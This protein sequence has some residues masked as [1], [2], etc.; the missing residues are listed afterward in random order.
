MMKGK[1]ENGGVFGGTAPQREPSP[2]IN[3][4]SKNQKLFSST[5]NGFPL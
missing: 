4:E 1:N 3:E 5:T 2:G